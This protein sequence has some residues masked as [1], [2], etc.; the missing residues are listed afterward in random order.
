MGLIISFITG[1][2]ILQKGRKTRNKRE[3]ERERTEENQ[4]S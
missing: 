2:T 3:R 1:V 4:I